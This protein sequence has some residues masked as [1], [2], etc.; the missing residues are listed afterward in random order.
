MERMKKIKAYCSVSSLE[1]EY[2][3]SSDRRFAGRRS[4]YN[5]GWYFVDRYRLYDVGKDGTKVLIGY[6]DVKTTG[7]AE[8][9][10]SDRH[11]GIVTRAFSQETFLSRLERYVNNERAEN[12]S[13]RRD[14][15]E[16]EIEKQ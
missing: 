1:I 6:L 13:R 16:E 4:F 9:T 14:M 12:L 10:L 5:D 15:D 11:K 8:F 2:S 3:G 7:R